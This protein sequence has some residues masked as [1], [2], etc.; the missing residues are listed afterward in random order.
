MFLYGIF[1]FF[2]KF[3]DNSFVFG[4]NVNL[5][6]FFFKYFWIIELKSFIKL[7][8]DKVNRNLNNIYCY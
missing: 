4:C 6:V 1:K 5:F 8:F 3:N 7:N 2:Y